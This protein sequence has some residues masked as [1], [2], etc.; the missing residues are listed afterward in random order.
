MM[1]LVGAVD[2]ATM[3]VELEL[4]EEHCVAI[5]IVYP[6]IVPKENGTLVIWQDELDHHDDNGKA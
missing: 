1:T 6:F 3:G 4:G 2:N 5:L